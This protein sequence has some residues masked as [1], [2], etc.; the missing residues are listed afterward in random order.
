MEFKESILMAVNSLKVNKLR[1]FLTLLGIIIGV[2][3]IIAVMT[4]V[5]VLQNNIE[6]TFNILGSNTFTVQKYPAMQFGHG[7][8][9]KYKNRKDLTLD[10]GEVVR[11]KCQSASYVALVT[12]RWGSTMKHNNIE[13]PPTII[14]RAVT[15][16][17]FFTFN[18]IVSEG[19][20]ISNQ[21]VEY[22]RDVIVLGKDLVNK[23]FPNE[24]PLDKKVRLDG[25]EFIVIGYCES[26]G[27][28]FGMSQDNFC[29]MPITSY[30]QKYGKIRQIGIMVMSKSQEDYQKALEE[31]MSILRIARKVPPGK[32]ND[33]EIVSNESL[34]QQINGI[35]LYF[36]VGAGIIAG[37][38]LLAAG[39]GIMNIMLVSVTE[40]IKEIGVRKA[41]GARKTNIL[42]QF[43]IEAV[44]VC[45]FG[46]IIGIFLGILC[47]NIAAIIFK[48]PPVF[49]YDWALIGLI[50]CSFIGIIFGVYPAWKAANLDPVE[51]L[52]YE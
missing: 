8:A 12:G 30:A 52:R 28:L 15:P 29:A 17:A 45:E 51:S 37:I 33:F 42:T 27:S 34:I 25:T 39:I 21:D 20:A 13:S 24:S 36:K 6:E 35:T 43:L 18:W 48:I 16:E 31:T 1:A 46:G 4:A 2:F 3:S 50:V 47:G 32:D 23:L 9:D 22:S 38:A 49:P 5:G 10:E 14:V 11:E 40:R 19:R 44:V 26:K 7:L 41:V